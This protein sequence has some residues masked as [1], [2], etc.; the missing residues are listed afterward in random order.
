MLRLSGFLVVLCLFVGWGMPAAAHPHGWVVARNEIVF[1]AEGKLTGFRH[2]WTDG[3][4][5]SKRDARDLARLFV[6]VFPGFHVMI[7]AGVDRSRLEDAV[8]VLLATSIERRSKPASSNAHA[9]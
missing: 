4:V 3:S 1:D 8:R 6:V 9:G 7:R 5:G 2:T